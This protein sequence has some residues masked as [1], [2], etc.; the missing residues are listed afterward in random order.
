MN[1]S[2]PPRFT[3]RWLAMAL[4]AISH[5]AGGAENSDKARI[6]EVRAEADAVLV[7]Q[8]AEC[9]Q[10]FAVNSCLLEARRQHRS[11]VGPLREELLLLDEKQRKQRA[12]DRAERIRAKAESSS[13]ATVAPT[14]SVAASAPAIAAP[15]SAPGPLIRPRLRSIGPTGDMP[16]ADMPVP[17]PDAAS[18]STG[19]ADVMATDPARTPKRHKPMPDPSAMEHSSD[20]L[21]EIEARR[22]SVLKRNAERAALKPPSAPLPVPAAPA[23]PAV[24][25]PR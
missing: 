4:L 19:V 24:P 1:P 22:N 23:S 5:V 12:V 7:A 14:P 8:E 13:G 15:H 25:P 10:R 11:V 18:T 20:R 3:H 17:I 16:S 9:H 21:R 6:N 2:V